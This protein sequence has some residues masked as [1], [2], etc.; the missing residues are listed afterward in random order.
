M[1]DT[2]TGGAKKAS[3]VYSWKNRLQLAPLEDSASVFYSDWFTYMCKSEILQQQLPSFDRFNAPTLQKIKKKRC[4]ASPGNPICTH[5]ICTGDLTVVMMARRWMWRATEDGSRRS[6]QWWGG[7]GSNP[8]L[9]LASNLHNVA[10]TSVWWHFF[11]V[12]SHRADY[13]FI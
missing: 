8:P 12:F 4:P 7:P 2:R 1:I 13:W 9:N 6:S 11:R 3:H 5:I 10:L